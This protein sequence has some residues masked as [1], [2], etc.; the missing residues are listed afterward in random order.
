MGWFWRR[1]LGEAEIR[2]K[3]E[4]RNTKWET[5]LPG[6]EGGEKAWPVVR[7]VLASKIVRERGFE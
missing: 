5:W 4:T 3:L 6:G 2:T 1:L 7:A